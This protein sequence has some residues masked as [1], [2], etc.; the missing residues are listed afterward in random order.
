MAHLKS[1]K[2][3]K[4]WPLGVKTK[5]FVSRPMAGPHG[6]ATALPLR[7]VIRDIFK[8]TKNATEADKA[9][10]AGK[11]LV[12]KVARKEPNF[13]VG[14][15][16]SVEVPEAGKSFRALPGKHGLEF[17]EAKD[18]GQKLCKVTGQTTVKGGKQQLH[19]H[20]GRNILL[21]KNGYKAGDSI[22]ISLPGQKVSKHLKLEEGAKVV[23]V[24]GK[25]KGVSGKLKSMRKARTML[26]K[27][28]AV[29]ETKEGEIETLLGYVMVTE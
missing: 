13:P 1:Y 6:I 4:G 8:M 14:I 15:M 5:V 25:N 10:K 17:V 26:E 27:S 16:D 24:K 7:V 18:T 3:P 11:V 22:V 19:L 29:V 21:A 12:D 28:T 9:I 2:M 20:D 23:V